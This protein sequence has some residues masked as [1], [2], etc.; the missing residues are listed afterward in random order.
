MDTFYSKSIFVH[1]RNHGVCRSIEKMYPI[2]PQHIIIL[3]STEQPNQLKR[4]LL[5]ENNTKKKK[6]Q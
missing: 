3:R 5:I 1:K 4:P 2:I 6:Q